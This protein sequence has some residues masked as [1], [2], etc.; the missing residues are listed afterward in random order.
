VPFWSFR[1]AC[2]IRQELLISDAADS[3]WRMKVVHDDNDA[4]LTYNNVG[5]LRDVASATFHPA[6]A[7]S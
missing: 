2:A 1:G 7:P 5:D 6:A 4:A 3:V